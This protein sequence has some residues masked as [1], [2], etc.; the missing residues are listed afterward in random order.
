MAGPTY[1]Y[2][3][4]PASSPKDAV[5]FYVGD[6]DVARPLLS[7]EEYAFLL[8][9]TN[10]ADT[11]TQAAVQALRI[12]ATKFAREADITVG[13]ISKSFSQVSKAFAERADAL[14]EQLALSYAIPY[15]GGTSRAAKDE[16]DNNVD[17][18]APMFRIGQFD[19]WYARQFD[20][21]G[22][23]GWWGEAL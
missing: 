16:L 8:S 19:S 21:L 1:T 3:G 11:A 2:S 12:L 10:P 9:G 23:L 7:D 15:F 14:E 5:R 20:A 17:G 22:R 4:N 13:D 18:V 6:V